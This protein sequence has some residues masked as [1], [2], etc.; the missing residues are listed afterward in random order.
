MSESAEGLHPRRYNAKEVVT[1]IAMHGAL[2]AIDIADDVTRERRAKQNA[3]LYT[4]DA[5]PMRRQPRDFTSA[6][7]GTRLR[8]ALSVARTLRYA[9]CCATSVFDAITPDMMARVL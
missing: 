7:V 8:R 1:D 3:P 6:F 4:A 9:R 5:M 2:F